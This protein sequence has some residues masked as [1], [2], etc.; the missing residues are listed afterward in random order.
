MLINPD[1]MGLLFT[2]TAGRGMLL[3]AVVLEVLGAT[4]MK[5]LLAIEI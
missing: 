4:S 1:Y 5:K 2:T 3:A